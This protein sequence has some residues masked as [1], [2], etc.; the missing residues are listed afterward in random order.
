MDKIVQVVVMC[1]VVWL[2][3]AFLIPLLPAPFGT[4]ALIL[5]VLGVI[6]WLMKTFGLW[7]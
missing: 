2:I 6:V 1:V 5:V 3:I 7:F 4:V